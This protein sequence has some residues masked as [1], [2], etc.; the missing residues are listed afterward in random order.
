MPEDAFG[1]TVR[2]SYD[3]SSAFD[4]APNVDWT[5]PGT[6]APTIVGD[7]TTIDTTALA[8]DTSSLYGTF[9]GTVGA[10]LY[11]YVRCRVDSGQNTHPYWYISNG[12]QRCLVQLCS[13][14]NQAGLARLSAPVSGRTSEVDTGAGSAF[15]ELLAELDPSGLL[16]IRDYQTM[17][18]ILGVHYDD[19][20][21]DGTQYTRIGDLSTAETIDMTLK[22]YPAL[23]VVEVP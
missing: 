19:C 12:A 1:G 6:V 16:L 2:Q 4:A 10:K 18:P 11:G 15:V 20:T 9:G 8:S 14:S 22:G 5:N 23:A 21:A 17:V 13:A 7:E 3:A